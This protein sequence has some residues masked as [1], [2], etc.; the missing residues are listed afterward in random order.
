MFL[1]S[2]KLYLEKHS[3]F[4]NNL[5]R[6]GGGLEVCKFLAFLLKLRLLKKNLQNAFQTLRTSETLL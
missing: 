6:G 2:Y 1:A 5:K 4:P 3:L